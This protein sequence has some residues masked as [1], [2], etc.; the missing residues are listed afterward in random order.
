MREAGFED[1][2]ESLANVSLASCYKA[3]VALLRRRI[4]REAEARRE[5]E[6][7][8]AQARREAELR[9]ADE[10]ARVAQEAGHG[11]LERHELVRHLDCV[12]SYT[13]SSRIHTSKA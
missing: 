12:D 1:G 10:E 4:Q 3:S 9:R 5:A 7:R 11:T 13:S 2:D 6:Q 8:E